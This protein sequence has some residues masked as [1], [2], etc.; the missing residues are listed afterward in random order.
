M[1]IDIT[2]VTADRLAKIEVVVRNLHHALDLRQHGDGAAWRA[3]KQIE[4]ILGL[5]YDQGAEEKRRRE[6]K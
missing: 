4:E 3:I 1:T 2:E 6:G 5:P